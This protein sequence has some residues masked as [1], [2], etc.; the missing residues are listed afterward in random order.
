MGFAFS[1]GGGGPFGRSGL[2][3]TLLKHFG[4]APGE[5]ATAG[6]Q[7]RLAKVRREDVI[8]PRKTLEMFDR[9]VAGFMMAREQ[10][11]RVVRQLVTAEQVG[12]LGEYFRLARF[13]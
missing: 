1:V 3:K 10:Q 5:I 9:N 6:R 12:L 2:R 13:L 8:L 11:G 7:H 4:V